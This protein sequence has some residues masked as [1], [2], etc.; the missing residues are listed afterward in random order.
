MKQKEKNQKS[1]EHILEF[2][3]AEFA[4][5]GYLG[6]SVNTICGAG[7]ISKGLL[8]HYY[9]DKD[10]LHLDCV[11]ACFQELTADLLTI[12]VCVLSVPAMKRAASRNMQL[13]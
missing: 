2:A 12:L 5:Q 13:P 3:F 4:A 6:A 1:R 8:Y 11:K 10:A 9:T 7:N